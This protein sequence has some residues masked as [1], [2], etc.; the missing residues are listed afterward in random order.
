VI[1]PLRST[2]GS[3]SAE[4]VL[5]STQMVSVA[6]PENL[7]KVNSYFCPN[8]KCTSYKKA[9]SIPAHNYIMKALQMTQE[10]RLEE[11]QRFFAER[12]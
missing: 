1:L 4:A 6:I 10:A 5:T 7:L 9:K 3:G 11:I 2:S 8:L 12:F